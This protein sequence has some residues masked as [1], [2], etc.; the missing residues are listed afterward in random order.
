MYLH[1]LIERTIRE[2]R[3][4]FP[5]VVI[6]GPRQSG[7]STLLQNLFKGKKVTYLSLE[8]PNLRALLKEDSLSY[9]ERQA[10]PVIL[11]EIQY[12]P[13]IM[14]TVKILIDQNR[15]PGTWFITGS[16]QFSVMKNV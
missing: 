10:K 6:T 14:H 13:E 2:V 16:Q 4:T 1:R 7:K 11:D 3:A 8:D 15:K 9:L 5:A 12:F